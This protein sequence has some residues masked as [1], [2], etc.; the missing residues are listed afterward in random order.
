[1]D[2]SKYPNFTEDEFR[3]KHTGRI[4]MTPEFMDALQALRTEYGKPIPVNS[5]YRDPTHPEEAKKSTPGQH[6]H[7][8]AVDISC[9]SDEAYEIVGLAYKH[10]FTG[11]G[12]S[13][14]QGKGRFVHLDRREGTPVLYSY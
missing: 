9:W 11:I 6:S 2:W 3:C 1:M 12:V 5:G 14:K 8:L 13:Q 7:G 4:D 10:G